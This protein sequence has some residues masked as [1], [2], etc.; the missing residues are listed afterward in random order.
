L[1]RSDSEELFYDD[2]RERP[3]DINGKLKTLTG[4][5]MVTELIDSRESNF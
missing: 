2:T 3:V 5:L 4:I 1:Q